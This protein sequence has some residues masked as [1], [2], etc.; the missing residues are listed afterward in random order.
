MKA[1][2]AQGYN[3]GMDLRDYFAAAVVQGMV[4]RTGRAFDEEADVELA[5]LVADLMMK[6]REK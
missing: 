4:S 1:F 2:P 6:V 5:Y 3:D